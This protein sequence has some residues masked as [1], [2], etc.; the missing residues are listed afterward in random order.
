MLE[1]TGDL[2]DELQAAFVGISGMGLCMSVV[3]H[4]L[5]SHKGILLFCK[6]KTSNCCYRC[7]FGVAC[8][9][10]VLTLRSFSA[11]FSKRLVD[12]QQS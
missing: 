8:F 10:A 1:N 4:S 5:K 11:R 6:S 2:F 7:P 9:S 12:I 3:I